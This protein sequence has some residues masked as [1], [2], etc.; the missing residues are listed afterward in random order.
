MFLDKS[1]YTQK[2]KVMAVVV[3][4]QMKIAAVISLVD[5]CC[6]RVHGTMELTLT[7]QHVLSNTR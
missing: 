2:F 3:V 4:Y 7:S 1:A 5:L 6:R